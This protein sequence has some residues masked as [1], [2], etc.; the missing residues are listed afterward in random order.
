MPPSSIAS[1]PTIAE[2]SSPRIGDCII[3]IGDEHEKAVYNEKNADG[4]ESGTSTQEGQLQVKAPSQAPSR[5]KTLDR[6]ES[7]GV[8]SYLPCLHSSL[9]SPHTISDHRKEDGRRILVQRIDDHPEGYPQL[10]AFLDSDRNFLMCRKFGWLRNR[11]LLYRQDELTLQSRKKD[12]G[13]EDIDYAWSR[14]KLIQDIDDKMKQ[15]DDLVSRLKSY[16]SLKTPSS[17]NYNSFRSWILDRKPLTR[18]ETKFVQYGDDFVA[19]ADGAEDGCIDGMV[20]DVL[21]CLPR[22]IVKPIFTSAEQRKKSDD[23]YVHLY[24][25]RRIDFLVRV[26]LALVT[27]ILLLV[28]TALLF[29]VPGS[30][31]LKIMTILLFTLLFST[32][33]MV[34]TK[35]KRHEMVAA[36]AAYCA[37]L[38]VFLGNFVPDAVSAKS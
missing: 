24:S 23:K 4:T 5:Q 15:Y 29:L 28:P 9:R 6:A 33:L 11:V 26:I 18:E 25:K 8:L 7:S 19:L 13:R 16:V 27:V 36:S 37:V 35:A 17:R 2:Q 20:E 10:A 3:E 30:N 12:N 31:R 32:A 38:V 1:S 14:Q 21:G 34:F 22:S